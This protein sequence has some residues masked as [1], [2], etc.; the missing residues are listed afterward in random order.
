MAA[1]VVIDVATDPARIEPDALVVLVEPLYAVP[2]V[3]LALDAGW[4]SVELAALEPGAAPIPLVS[5]EQPP[6]PEQRGGRC[7]VR[8]D[9]L[10]HASARVMTHDIVVLGSP[11]VAR[12]LCSRIAAMDHAGVTFV[13]AAA[14]GEAMPADGWWAAGMLVRVLLEELER[15]STLTDPAGL[16]VTIAQ[17]AEDAAAQL[18]AGVRWRTHLERGGHADDLRLA[19]AVDSIGVVPVLS[20]SG[21]VIVARPWAPPA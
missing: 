21:D 14:G 19:A 5:F 15:D 13:P 1:P 18:S 16:A 6:G 11:V 8:S 4:G 3:A 9:D 2:A 17:G 20:R 12:P 10:A 7:R